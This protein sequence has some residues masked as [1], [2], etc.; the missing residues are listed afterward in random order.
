MPKS[1]SQNVD[2]GELIRFGIVAEVRETRV[3]I[4]CGDVRTGPIRWLD[5]RSGDTRTRSRPSVGEQVLLLCPGGDIEAAIAIPGV[6]S[7]KFPLP[8]SG[9][10]ELIH[11]SDDAAIGYDPATHALAAVLPAGASA[12][13]T[14][15]MGVSLRVDADGVAIRGKLK[16]DGDVDVTGKLTADAD[17][18][19]AGKSLKSHKHLGV[20][21]GG[22]VSGLPQ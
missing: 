3:V 12:E 14:I 4:D 1:D 11:F 9:A 17:V 7:D 20:Q 6:S 18:V 10:E 15:G 22:G 8:G 19:G 16:I 2:A 21:P 5:R 13:I